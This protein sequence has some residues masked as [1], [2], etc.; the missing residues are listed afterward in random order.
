MAHQFYDSKVL[1]IIDETSDVKRFIIEFNKDIPF[2]FRAGQFVMLNFPINAKISHRSY[3]IASPPSDDHIFELVIVLNPKGLGTPWMWENLKPGSPIPVS[4]PLGKFGLPPQLDADLCFICTGVGI[5]PFRSMLFDIIAKNT[6][7]KN[8][9]MVFGTRHEKDMLYRKEME[10]IAQKYP[11]F[12]FIPTLS[13]ES[14]PAWMGHKGY[15]HPIYVELFVDKR[16]GYFY[17][18]G[19]ND[20]LNEARKNLAEMGYDKKQ[21][22]F[23]SYD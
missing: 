13:R 1:D 23:E 6:P 12:K 19:W 17:I 21:I 9:Y 22:K 11:D 2:S 10:E 8:I 7:H 4:K 14:S 3:S 15:V 5:A 16:P 20:M 18:C